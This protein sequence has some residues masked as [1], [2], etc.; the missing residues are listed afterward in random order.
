MD[1]KD[2]TVTRIKGASAGSLSLL[3]ETVKLAQEHVPKLRASAENR[4][5]FRNMED[6][7]SKL[8]AHCRAN[9]FDPTRTYQHVA[10]FDSEI[11]A[12]VVKMFAKED[13]DG[14]L[15]DDGLLYKWDNRTQ[16]VVLNKDFFYALL[17][18][19][20][21]CGIPCDMRGKIKIN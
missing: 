1:A 13:D 18:Y 9:G 10:N 16:N 17:G 21:A 4:V 7:M 6:A 12:L 2:F 20:E 11:W 19:L 5:E 3:G 14:N 8:G 15:L